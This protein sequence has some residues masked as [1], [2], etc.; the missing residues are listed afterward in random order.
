MATLYNEKFLGYQ[1]WEM[2]KIRK[3]KKIKIKKKYKKIK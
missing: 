3:K 2:F 1:P